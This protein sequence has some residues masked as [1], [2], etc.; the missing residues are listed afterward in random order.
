MLILW[1]PL[2][3][4]E[5]KSRFCFPGLLGHCWN[6][7]ICECMWFN[8]AQG[9]VF[10]FSSMGR[11]WGKGDGVP[12]TQ[13]RIG[14]AGESFQGAQWGS[15]GHRSLGPTCAVEVEVGSYRLTMLLILPSR[16]ITLLEGL[17]SVLLRL[18]LRLIVK[19]IF[20]RQILRYL[21]HSGEFDIQP[22]NTVGR[23]G[24]GGN[25]ATKNQ[26]HIAQPGD[27]R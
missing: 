1:W 19:T 14:T 18:L 11:Q 7:L 17:L 24:R 25:G 10:I 3:V 13:S 26:L 27:S 22:P 21:R 16:T 20:L 8:G 12:L 9:C 15:T 4:Q 23:K 2:C 6:G 5:R